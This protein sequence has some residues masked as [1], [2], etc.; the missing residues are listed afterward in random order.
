MIWWYLRGDSGHGWAVMPIRS[1]AAR[2]PNVWGYAASV[3]QYR[4]GDRLTWTVYTKR[5]KL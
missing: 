3:I 4:L 2:D 5:R 1:D